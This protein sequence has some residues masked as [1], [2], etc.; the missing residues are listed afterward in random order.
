M[1]IGRFTG[2]N[3][4]C[5]RWLRRSAPTEFRQRLWQD[6]LSTMRNW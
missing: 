2:A 4:T 1:L 5:R 6:N 3:V